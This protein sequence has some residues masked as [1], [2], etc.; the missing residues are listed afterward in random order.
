MTAAPPLP[1]RVVLTPNGR[2]WHIAGP[3]TP[4]AYD[5]IRE[6]WTICSVAGGGQ[7]LGYTVYRDALDSVRRSSVAQPCP[8][9]L[10][11]WN[12]PRPEP[13]PPR[14][15]ELEEC[16]ALLPAVRGKQ[17]YCSQKHYMKVY[18]RQRRAS[19]AG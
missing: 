18:Y 10:E 6:Y 4:L 11:R 9:C 3:R 14:Y 16:G 5:G 17:R 2:V 15:C 12:A 1:D 7:R 13:P 8:K 19:A